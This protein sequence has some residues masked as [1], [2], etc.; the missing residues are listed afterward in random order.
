[1]KLPGTKSLKL[2]IL[3]QRDSLLHNQNLYP[4][5]KEDIERLTPPHFLLHTPFPQLQHFNRYLKAISIRLDRA[6]LNA[7][8]D[9]DKA[10]LI[11][12]YDQKLT[13]WVTSSSDSQAVLDA[14]NE[15]RWMIEEFRVS[16]FAQELG[17]AYPISTIRL[18]K[19]IAELLRLAQ[20]P[21]EASTL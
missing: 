7:A 4:G 3:T 1:M 20:T 6:R 10:A 21:K 19:K 13:Q 2:S 15:L 12:P 8:K 17:T 9:A 11:R 16:L 5:L 18:D 14:I